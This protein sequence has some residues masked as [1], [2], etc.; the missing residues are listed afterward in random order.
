M[1]ALVHQAETGAPPQRQP[2]L[3]GPNNAEHLQTTDFGAG[4]DPYDQK[5]GP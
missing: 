5:R 4:E 2:E 1:G 3:V